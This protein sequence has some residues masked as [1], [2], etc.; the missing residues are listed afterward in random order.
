MWFRTGSLFVKELLVD[1]STI[2]DTY[3]LLAFFQDG[4]D[5]YELDI[6]WR[7]EPSRQIRER[8]EQI[9]RQQIYSSFHLVGDSSAVSIVHH[10]AG[11]DVPLPQRIDFQDIEVRTKSIFLEAPKVGGIVGI[12]V[13]SSLVVDPIYHIILDS[14][15]ATLLNLVGSVKAIYKY[16]KDLEYYATRDPLTFL[17][18]QRMFWEMLDYETGRADRHGYPFGLLVIDMDNFKNINDTYGHSFG[19]LFLQQLAETLRQSVRKGDFVARY[20]GDEFIVLLPETGLEQVHAVAARIMLGVSSLAVAAP[21][22]AKVITTISIGLAMYPEHGKTARD[23][24]MVADNMMYKVKAEGKNAIAAPEME[25]VA[26]IF[27]TEGEMNILVYQ[28]VEQRSPLPYFQAIF[29]FQ[30]G[31]PYAHE[32][33]MRIPNPGWQV[34]DGG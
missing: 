29:D 13:Q 1:I 4:E 2:I 16:T 5:K 14:V 33:L 21:D 3:A 32:L 12:G 27:K 9:V 28:A 31:R 19:D 11:S 22:G 24:F 6:F 17:H 26:E 30:T 7:S 34:A 15:L 25:D 8:M 18:N 20:G 10:N 23:L